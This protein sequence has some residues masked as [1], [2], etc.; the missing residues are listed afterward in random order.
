MNTNSEKIIL[1][2]IINAN[3]NPE[4]NKSISGKTNGIANFN[5]LNIIIENKNDNIVITAESKRSMN[6]TLL[7]FAPRLFIIATSFFL[8]STAI[9]EKELRRATEINNNTI[10]N[11]IRAMLKKR[12]CIETLSFNVSN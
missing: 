12:V 2:I 8:S 11:N 5:I 6:N 10:P 9:L 4:L 1:I 7:L 3:G